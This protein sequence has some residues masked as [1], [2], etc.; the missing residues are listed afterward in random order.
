MSREQAATPDADLAEAI[1]KLARASV[2]VMGDAML[3]RYV[4]GS[5]SRISPEAP[6]PVLSA[7]R[8]LALPGGAG[9]VVRNLTALG[10][11]VAF[12]SVVGDDQAGS[13]LTGLIGGQPNVEPWL[14]VQGGRCTTVKTRFIARGQQLLRSDQETHGADP[15]Q[16]RRAHVAYRR[17][18]DGR[19][20]RHR[21]VGLRQGRPRRR[22]RATAYRGGTRRFPARRGLAARQQ[23]RPLCRRRCG[24]AEPAG[25][26]NR[27]RHERID[28]R[29]GSRSPHDGCARRT[30]SGP[31]WSIAA[32]RGF[33]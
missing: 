16:A 26:R 21:A 27:H 23:L 11:A 30:A 14:L 33:P 28:R 15:R 2:M 24:G 18:R 8:E 12:V 9:N 13:D 25:S 20:Q 22:C 31:C 32:W 19:D 29:P 5:V 17:R 3:D 4:F 10:A 6:V 1:P 7:E